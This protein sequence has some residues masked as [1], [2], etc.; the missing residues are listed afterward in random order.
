MTSLSRF[1]TAL[2]RRLVLTYGLA[3]AGGGVAD[4]F[5]LPLAWMLGPFFVCGAVA[6][7]GVQLATLPFTRELG[8]LTIGLA[9]GLRF[10][11]A[12]LLAALSLLPAMLAASL[13]V[14]V[15]T[16]IAA[17]LFRSMA[18]VSATTAFFA[19]AAGG[20][21]DMANV[22]GEKGGDRAAVGITHALRVSTTVA[23]VPLLVIAFG[24]PGTISAAVPMTSQGLAWLTL[25]FALALPVIRLMGRTSLPNPW[26]VAPMLVGLV[27]SLSG[28]LTVQMPPLLLMLAQLMLGTW[29]GCQFRREVLASLPRV[30]LAGAAITLFMVAA[31]YAGAWCLSAMT[32][33]SISTAFLALAPAAMAE[34][35]LTAKAMHLDV[36]MVIAFHVTRIFLVCSTILS[37][38]HLYNRLMDVMTSSNPKNSE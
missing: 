15:Y 13:Y 38:F 11:P 8:Q 18:G 10:G 31:A 5:G 19:T 36:E 33:L 37:V 12:T 28:T 17:I 32:S 9:I 1:D 3:V 35:V 2:F 6:A 14:M 4:A 30:S 29:L 7:F 27:L 22:A 25:A 26:L 16:M 34:M 20:M 23:T 24:A 21:A